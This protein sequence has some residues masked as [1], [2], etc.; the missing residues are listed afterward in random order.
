MSDNPFNP[1]FG[2]VPPIFIDRDHYVQQIVAGLGNSNSPMQ[3]TLISGVRGVGKTVL[4][5]DISHRLEA[6]PTWIVA[7]IPSNGEIM[8]TLV[9]SVRE[10]ASSE[11][12]KAIDSIEGISISL[13]GIGVSYSNAKPDINYQ[14]L[15]E[16][17]MIESKK[18]HISLLIVTRRFN[19][20]DYRRFAAKTF[21]QIQ[22]HRERS[23]LLLT[24]RF[25][26]CHPC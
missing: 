24:A 2:K 9:Q 1:S 23:V 19:I 17:I 21:I 18:K 7:D 20:S 8:E 10:K 3:T 14:L 5:A 6:D 11:V 13:L 16:K 15:L 12:R 25:F 22:Y 26:R 4:L